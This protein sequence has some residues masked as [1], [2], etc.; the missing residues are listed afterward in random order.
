MNDKLAALREQ[1]G[2]GPIQLSARHD[3]LYERHLLFDRVIDPQDADPHDQWDA[4]A[5]AL[6]D[7]ISQRWIKTEKT[8]ARENPKR[9]YY[10]S[11]EFLLG[12]SL[13][14]NLTNLLLGP[15]A[16]KAVREKHLDL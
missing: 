10:L 3:G 4:A 14:N 7:F 11:M 1:Y 8:Y 9:V 12:R 15:V 2:C 5:H 16:E 13:A 6:R